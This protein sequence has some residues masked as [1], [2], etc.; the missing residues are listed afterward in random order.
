[1]E[2]KQLRQVFELVSNAVSDISQQLPKTPALSLPY[3][4]LL[5]AEKILTKAVQ[6]LTT[7]GG[8]G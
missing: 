6:N 7:P 8:N 3:N 2:E 5:T 1:M 4:R